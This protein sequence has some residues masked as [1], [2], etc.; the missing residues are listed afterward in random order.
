MDAAWITPPA[1]LAT[2]AALLAVLARKVTQATEEARGAQH[3]FRRLE[4]GLIPVRVESRRTRA[5]V[6]RMHHR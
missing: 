3:R 4:D 5:S 1:V 2:G 6:D